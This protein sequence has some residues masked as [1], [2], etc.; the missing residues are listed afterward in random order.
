MEKTYKRRVSRWLPQ[1]KV[2]KLRPKYLG[3]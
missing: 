3:L 2:F 1:Q